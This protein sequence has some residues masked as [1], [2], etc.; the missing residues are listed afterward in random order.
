[1]SISLVS[2][3][4]SDVVSVGPTSKGAYVELADSLGKLFGASKVL[5]SWNALNFTS[6]ASE[7]VLTLTPVRAGVAGST[8]TTIPVTA[9][10]RLVLIGMTVFMK[11]AG[12]AVQWVRCTLRTNPTGAAVATSPVLAICA[13]GSNS[14]VAANSSGQGFILLSSGFPCLIEFAGTEQ[15]CVTQISQGATAGNDMVLWGYEY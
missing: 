13:S 14:A 2:G 4:S 12:A 10:K 1:M 3:V 11:N 9:G 15:L 5:C 7:A 8:Y 6:A